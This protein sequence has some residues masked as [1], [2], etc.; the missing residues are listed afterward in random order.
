MPKRI[1][2]KCIS[3]ALAA[4]LILSLVTVSAVSAGALDAFYQAA[5]QLKIKDHI[6]KDASMS[7]YATAQGSCTDGKYAYFAVLSGSAALLK[8]DLSNFK[9]VKKNSS[10]AALGHANDITYNSKEKMLLVA[11]NAPNYDIITK[12]DPE[13][14]TVTGTVKIKLKI[15]SI[16]Y[17]ED[18]DCYFVGIS[19]GYNF[20]RL[21]KNFKVV[22]KYK[23]TNTGYTR[24]GCDCDG[25]YIYFTQSGSGDNLIVVYTVGGAYVTTI[26]VKHSYEI[27]NIFHKGNDFFVTLHY[28]GNFIYR[29]G[30]SDKT[31]I[32]YTVSYDPGDG[33]GEM[34]D[35][36]VH[37]GHEKKL[38]KNTFTKSG[39]F[40]GGWKIKRSIDNKV[41]GYRKYSDKSEW[42]EEN[43]A[44]SYYLLNDEATV[45]KTTKLGKI[46]L[47]PFFI[48]EYYTVTFESDADGYV[49][50]MLVGYSDVFALPQ[51]SYS[52]HGYVFT[53]YSLSRD[54]DN[55]VFGY[56]KGS[57]KPMWVYED[58]LTEKYLFSEGEEVTALTYDGS[59]TFTAE[60]I[61]AFDY[62]ADGTIL[63]KYN[64]IDEEVDIPDNDGQLATVGA[65]SFVDNDIIVSIDFPATVT[66]VEGD[67]IVN[68]HYL[69]KM[70]FEEKLPE[71]LSGAA[72][73]NSGTPKIYL[74]AGD[75]MIFMGWY[76]D[77]VSASAMQLV[78]HKMKE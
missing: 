23:G 30:L 33:E 56:R 63:V 10:L 73:N 52:K 36:S 68:C 42:I 14:L 76:R 71:N 28:Y 6:E 37:Y 5:E 32:R 3:I 26:R 9:C 40:F 43:Q 47:T 67:A 27:E 41:Y 12:V 70:Y 17:C 60:F 22:K 4:A 25:E 39:Y 18:L 78:E 49:P 61:L 16:A 2:S 15:Y 51:N 59:V 11:N 58:D 54:I 64:G 19:G 75:R 77:F 1:L 29:V 69:E 48:N 20:A 7:K 45:S 38:R 31:M 50:P 72:L 62:S 74:K 8:Y 46:T 44:D 55:K 66:T 57:T 13:T 65:H 24:Q 35:T 34:E 53:G 21:D